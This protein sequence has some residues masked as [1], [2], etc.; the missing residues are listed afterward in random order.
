MLCHGHESWHPAPEFYYKAGGGPM[1][2]M[3]PYYLTALVNM[4][5]AFRRITGSARVTFPERKIT[6]QP[7]YGTKVTV[8]VP[9]HIAA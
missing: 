4:L 1:F 7:L 8:D 2:D 5:G 9:T 6:S 3:G